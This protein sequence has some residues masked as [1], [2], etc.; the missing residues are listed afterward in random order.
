MSAGAKDSRVILVTGS[1]KG[2]GLE[3]VRQLSER[4]PHAHIL[5]GTRSL[6]NGEAALTNLRAAPD[7]PSTYTNIH[8]L[9][10]DVTDADSIQRAVQQ[11]QSHYGHLDVLLNNSGISNTDGDF[12]SFDVF[13]VNLYGVRDVTEAFLPLIPPGGAVLTNTSGVGAWAMYNLPASLQQRLTQPERLT[14]PDFDALAQDANRHL[15]GQPAQ[16]PWA[17]LGDLVNGAYGLS[18]A[19][20]NAWVRV[21]AYEHPESR[22]RVA[23]VTPGYCATDLNKHLGHVGTLPASAGGTAIIWPV[24]HDFEHGHFY[25]DEGEEYPWITKATFT[26]PPLA[27]AK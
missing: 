24:L 26:P 22:V 1:N 15:H 25:H 4:L 2:V 13:R 10:L 17:D 3:A 23:A 19:L 6:A 14:W 20:C 8:P 11:V 21:F 9:Q 12:S 16:Y 5:M 7:A 18:K 27:G